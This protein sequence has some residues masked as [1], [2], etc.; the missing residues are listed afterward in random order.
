MCENC[1]VALKIGWREYYR[2]IKM[3]VEPSTDNIN[4][5]LGEREENIV[6]SMV[7]GLRRICLTNS[8]PIWAHLYKMLSVNFRQSLYLKALT[9]WAFGSITH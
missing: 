1:K 5:H 4:N 6:Y 8:I 2:T 9:H 7:T 3:G